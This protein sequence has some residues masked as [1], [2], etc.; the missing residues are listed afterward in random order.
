MTAH[1]VCN[2]GER[3]AM[4]EES[5]KTPLKESGVHIIVVVGEFDQIRGRVFDE[6]LFH[7]GSDMYDENRHVCSRTLFREWYAELNLRRSR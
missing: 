2:Y 6:I 3:V 7:G 5:Q 4:F 1:V